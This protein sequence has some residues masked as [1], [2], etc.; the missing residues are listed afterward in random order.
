MSCNIND[1][2]QDVSVLGFLFVVFG[3][4]GF[5]AAIFLLVVMGGAVSI[6]G[7]V[8]AD[9]ADAA[10]VAPI[11]GLTVVIDLVKFQ[12]WACIGGLILSAVNSLSFSLG[13]ALGFYGLWILLSKETEAILT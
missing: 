8:G 1:M 9:D 5:L 3:T 6:I 4:L 13:T 11:L 10:V 7:A 2:K 12:D